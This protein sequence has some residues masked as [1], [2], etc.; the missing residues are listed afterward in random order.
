MMNYIKKNVIVTNYTIGHSGNNGINS[1]F[2]DVMMKLTLAMLH[3]K[4]IAVFEGKPK[5][6]PKYRTYIPGNMETIMETRFPLKIPSS[7]GLHN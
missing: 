7:S 1:L 3:L 6:M 2:T 4:V 5:K